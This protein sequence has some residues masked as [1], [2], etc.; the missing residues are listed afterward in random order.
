MR[1]TTPHPGGALRRATGA[2]VLVLGLATL[3][4]ACAAVAPERG[5]TPPVPVPTTGPT[6]SPSP[7]AVAERPVR[8]TI[9]AIDVDAPLVSVG[10]RPDGAMQT[11]ETGLAGW[12]DPG[13]RPGE[14]GAAVITAH[15]DSTAGPDV[16]HRLDALR[17]GDVA[18]VTDAAGAHHRF[19]VTRTDRVP[20]ERLPVEQIWDEPAHPGLRLITCGGAFDPATGHYRDNVVVWATGVTGS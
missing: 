7:S 6:A 1:A 5:T 11:P 2:V 10:L 16:F 17:P 13:P 20:K 8:I 4:V 12:Y 3:A 19:R 9:D 18:T 15:V 14:V